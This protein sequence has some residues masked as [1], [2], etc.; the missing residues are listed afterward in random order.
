MTDEGTPEEH[1]PLSGD[2]EPTGPGEWL[3]LDEA[4]RRLGI[5]RKAVYRRI[6]RGRMTGKKA[7]FASHLLVW[8]PEGEEQQERERGT[9]SGER[10]HFLVPD[11]QARFLELVDRATATLGQQVQQLTEEREQARR[12]RDE[13]IRERDALA[14]RLQASAGRRP[15][16]RIW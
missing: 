4:G 5:D 15:W 10:R 1:V 8:F 12:E 14:A 11:Q 13:A 2:V 7:P 16:W 6:R 9:E 3:T